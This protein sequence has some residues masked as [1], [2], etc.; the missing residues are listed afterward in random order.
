[1][2]MTFWWPCC[3]GFVPVCR[4]ELA[5]SA[6]R[7]RAGASQARCRPAKTAA[8]RAPIQSGGAAH[9]AG[10]GRPA[11][12]PA[13]RAR[14]GSGRA[15]CRSPG[16]GRR[17]SNRA[18]NA[19]YLAAR[20]PRCQ[21]CSTSERCAPIPANGP[22]NEK[23]S[24]ARPSC[25]VTCFASA[26]RAGCGLT[27]TPGSG[28]PKPAQVS[29]VRSLWRSCRRVS[30]T[31]T[32]SDQPAAV[33]GGRV[34][35][36]GVDARRPLGE[37]LVA[38]LRQRPPHAVAYR[39]AVIQPLGGQPGQRL[40]GRL[41]LEPEPPATWSSVAVHGGSSAGSTNSPRIGQRERAGAAGSAVLTPDTD[42]R[43]RAVSSAAVGGRL[44]MTCFP[45]HCVPDW[46]PA[47]LTRPAVDS[48]LQ[49][50]DGA[51]NVCRGYVH[52]VSRGRDGTSHACR[53]FQRQ[54]VPRWTARSRRAGAAISP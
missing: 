24:A 54:R 38:R 3:A 22:V 17:S 9:G 32:S 18:R 25:S 52:R 14:G 2:I 5:S 35:A 10:P 21:A 23:V 12:T 41:L 48:I 40:A 46:L 15:A 44:D 20:S 19:W 50:I 7:A 30:G 39:C 37:Q 36:E 29:R 4:A 27:H 51:L 11:G 43:P 13:T 53:V 28:L 6:Q 16:A 33:P 26:S 1:M 49:V 8:A 42:G 45:W 47:G 31:V 34:A